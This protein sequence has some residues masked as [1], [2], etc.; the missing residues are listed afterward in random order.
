[1]HAALTPGLDTSE[2]PKLG[3]G[4]V[5]V[6]VARTVA[7]G[8]E[9]RFEVLV[10]ELEREVV[11]FP[12]CLG[13]GV[14]RPGTPEGPYQLVFRFTDPVS[15]RRWERSEERAVQLNHLNEVVLDTRVQVDLPDL[16]RARRHLG[17]I[18]WVAP[19]AVVVSIVIAPYLQ[20]LSIVPRVVATVTLMTLLMG[21][22]VTPVRERWRK[23][24]RKGW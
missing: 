22:A 17:D 3:A 4:P 20:F 11:A 14:L 2:L 23:S 7:L 21:E 13:A 12:G 16:P 5:T 18:L 8:M 15:L 10:A 9:A 6:T 1:M 24:R 19:V